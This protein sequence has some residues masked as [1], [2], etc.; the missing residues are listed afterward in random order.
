MLKKYSY[1]KLLT[2]NFI[3]QPATFFR[4]KVVKETGDLNV[5]LHYVMDYEYWLRLGTKHNAGVIYEYLSNFRWYE[6]TK[7]GS[8]YKEQF[9]EELEISKKFTR[10]LIEIIYYQFHKLNYFKIVII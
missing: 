5:N 10:N 8:G 6:D 3:S 9:K 2:E 1:K 4:A 7:S